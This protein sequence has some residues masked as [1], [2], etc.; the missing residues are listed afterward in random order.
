VGAFSGKCGEGIGYFM[1]R[2]KVGEALGKVHRVVFYR[3]AGHPPYHRVSKFRASSAKF[4]H[5][6]TVS[7]Y[8]RRVNGHPLLPR[9]APVAPLRLDIF[10]PVS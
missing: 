10:S 9:T 4:F 5:A 1:R 6:F 2:L 8:D 7:G 3:S